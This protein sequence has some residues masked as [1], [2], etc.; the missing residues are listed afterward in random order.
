MVMNAS[1][2][3]LAQSLHSVRQGSEDSRAISAIKRQR[4]AKR[5]EE[6]A[7]YPEVLE[8]MHLSSFSKVPRISQIERFVRRSSSE[9]KDGKDTY[10]PQHPLE[11]SAPEQSG[12][13]V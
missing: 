10:S 11:K 2:A 3:N 8:K 7:K 4:Q 6:E 13:K 5:E 12:R 1:W 9:P